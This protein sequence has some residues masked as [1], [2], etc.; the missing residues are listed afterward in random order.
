M[1]ILNQRKNFDRRRPGWL[2]IDQRW[3]GAINWGV[4]EKFETRGK[5]LMEEDQVC[6]QNAKDQVGGRDQGGK[7]EY[8]DRR[9]TG[10]LRINQA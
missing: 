7:C 3:M 5:R 6:K 9:I 1:A 10:C 2:I 8:I 4:K